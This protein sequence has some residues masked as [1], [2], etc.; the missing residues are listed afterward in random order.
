MR[1]VLTPELKK[2]AETAA[3]RKSPVGT[4]DPG[5]CVRNCVERGP[6]LYSNTN[7]RLG[8]E[9]GV[10]KVPFPGIEVMDPRIVRIPPGR[11][12]ERHKH[13][14]ESIFVIVEGR[15][16]VLIGEQRVQVK[17]GDVAFVPR[18]LVHQT[19]N[20]GDTDLVVLA[21]TDFGFTSA[22]LGDYDR[23]TRLRE[24]GAD[25]QQE[26]AAR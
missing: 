26:E 9:F 10:E 4:V 16:E 13:A 8:I 24:G 11:N 19:S 14:H 5:A 20:T 1:D 7:E 18:W 3:S 17:A 25:A 15:G 2:L 21:I 23:R 6:A 12:N 22:V